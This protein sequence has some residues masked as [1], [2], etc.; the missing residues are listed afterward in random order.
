[1][2]T[3]NVFS[4][5]SK[6]TVLSVSAQTK[7]TDAKSVLSALS[8]NNKTYQTALINSF[9]LMAFADGSIQEEEVDV[10]IKFIEA[11]GDITDKA[12]IIENFTSIIKELEE[13]SSKSKAFLKLRINKSL[14]EIRKLTD[15]ELREKVFIMVEGVFDSK[16]NSGGIKIKRT[17]EEIE[18]LNKLKKELSPL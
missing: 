11:D 14:G 13:E 16:E 1:M 12:K 5:D 2:E 15:N 7:P 3:P 6:P 4:I 10:V 8:N 18:M 17:P 9:A